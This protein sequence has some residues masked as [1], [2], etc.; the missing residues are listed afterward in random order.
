MLYCHTVVCN[1]AVLSTL[2][3][4]CRASHVESWLS[5]GATVF[6]FTPGEP[7][8][9]SWCGI[10]GRD[11]MLSLRTPASYK[12]QQMV[13]DPT[14]Q[15]PGER[16]IC[17][18]HRT[19]VCVEHAAHWRSPD[20]VLG[21]RSSNLEISATVADSRGRRGLMHAVYKS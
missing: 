6:S 18:A 12:S 8:V 16:E 9:G 13:V 5:Q 17:F 2:I 10:D 20:H 19:P 1:T 15:T 3:P 14:S 7:A 4:V 11:G 21:P